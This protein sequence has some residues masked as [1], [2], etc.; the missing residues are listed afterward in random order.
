MT[1]A[2]VRDKKTGL[3]RQTTVKAYK[4]IPHRYTLLGYVDED[5]NPVD[6]PEEQPV[7][8]KRSVAAAPVAE[9]RQ[10]SAD[11]I[12]AKKAELKALNEAAF[13]KARKEQE[14][15]K[16]NQSAVTEAVEQVKER[17]NEE[18]VK[19]KKKPGPKPKTKTNA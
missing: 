5:G 10:M 3:E 2:R 19:E 7:Q 17:G 16:L 14:S 12:E 4:L 18:P 15:I 6:G 9:R 8:K 11:E 13:E 1:Y